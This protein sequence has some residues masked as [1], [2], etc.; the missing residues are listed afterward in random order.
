M[1][2]ESTTT[3]MPTK[4]AITAQ[5]RQGVSLIGV[6]AFTLV[7]CRPQTS[8]GRLSASAF[9]SPSEVDGTSTKPTRSYATCRASAL[10]PH[11]DHMVR[12]AVRVDDLACE[13]CT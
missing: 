2:T 11:L 6:G 8:N 9:S 4:N 3:N 7:L 13:G 1:N 5:W 10:P 12:S